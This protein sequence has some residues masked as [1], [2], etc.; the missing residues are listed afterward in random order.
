MKKKPVCF[1]D[2]IRKSLI[3]HA[4]VPCILS[5]IALGGLVA[6]VGFWQ[7]GEKNTRVL[8]HYSKEYEALI[9]QYVDENDK[10]C[11]TVDLERFS[12]SPS[13]RVSVVS[14]IY[15]FLGR[16][17]TRGDFYLFDRD[18]Q[19]IF[20]TRKNETK[21]GFLGSYMTE[22]PNGT[23][24]AGGSRL[25]FLYHE[26]DPDN[27]TVPAWLIFRPV[28]S[29]G[30]RSGYGGFLL[31]ADRFD[32]AMEAQVQVLVTNRFYRIF[33]KE[34]GRYEND[35]GKLRGE[36]R[37]GNGI[38]SF[39]GKWY[40]T[41]SRW[42]LDGNVRVYAIYDCTFFIQLG[43]IF[44]GLIVFVTAVMI[45]AIYHSAGRVADKKTEILYEL[46][47]A[48]E[49]VEKGDLTVHLEL[50]TGDEFER[51]GESFNMMLGSIRHLI[52]RHQELAKENLLASVQI[53]E[54][55]FNPHFLFNTLESI[56]Y[57]IQFDPVYAKKMIVD[58]SRLLRYSI[59]KGQEK[60]A[61][62]EEI[63][64]ID[65]Y[66]QIMLYRY[67]DRLNYK[68]EVEEKCRQMAVPRMILQPLV[69]N[70]IKYGFG[71]CL[72][73]LKIQVTAGLEEKKLLILIKDNGVGIDRILLEELRE[74]LKQAHNRSDHI[75]LYNVD[76]RIK[77]MYG[78]DY[79]L[80]IQSEKGKGT[81]VRL[82][83]PGE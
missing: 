73:E 46:I 26:H 7:I 56:R 20:S 66:L 51:I 8:K 11:Q 36:F 40:D 10:I 58:L 42:I 32:G 67:G 2:E 65:R 57:M 9:N 12:R 82:V 37:Q 4:L 18:R 39:E 61:L 49:Q 43:L 23:E 78:K 5:L 29:D 81:A 60:A 38:V 16:Q 19:L 48:L 62:S 13:Y 24:E 68:I 54:S 27:E 15:E 79:G 35:R 1:R 70:S 31:P 25:V 77:L 30:I 63:G 3:I 55:Q 53:L 17:E 14:G 69:E 52:A 64:F 33:T 59:Q 76:K 41:L 22:Y 71:D 47:A 28:L 34:A 74:N 80:S 45:W 21:A 6:A 83:L 44:A 72:D 75:G 50:L